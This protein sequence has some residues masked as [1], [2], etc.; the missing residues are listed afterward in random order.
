MMNVIV[1]YVSE[2]NIVQIVMD[3]DGNYKLA[4]GMSMEKGVKLCLA[5]FVAH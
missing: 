5:P 3:G 1:E 2:E 4:G